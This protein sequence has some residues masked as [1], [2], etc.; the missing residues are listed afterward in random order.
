[1]SGLPGLTRH[2]ILDAFVGSPRSCGAR[3]LHAGRPRAHCLPL[4]IMQGT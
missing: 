4:S 2:R 1:M 3:R